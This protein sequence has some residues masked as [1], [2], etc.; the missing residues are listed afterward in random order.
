MKLT[1][2]VEIEIPDD[3]KVPFSPTITR[4]K[5]LVIFKERVERQAKQMFPSTA[6]IT[7]SDR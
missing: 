5:D 3:S 1:V 4:E 6:T 2:Q 7:V